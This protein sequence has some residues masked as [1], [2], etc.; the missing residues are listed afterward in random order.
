[1]QR[2]SLSPLS[3]RSGNGFVSSAPSCAAVAVF[4]AAAAVVMPVF[5]ASAGEDASSGRAR[6]APSV[7]HLAPGAEQRFKAVMLQTRL[8]GATAAQNVAWSVNG[9]PGGDDTAG[10]ITADGLYTAPAQTPKPREVHICA[11]MADAANPH[12]FATVLFEGEGTHYESVAQWSESIAQPVHLKDPHCLALDHA[13]NLLIADFEGSRVHRFTPDGMYLGDLGL[14]TG[15]APGYVI[16]PRVVQVDHEGNI[17]VSDQKKDQ[18]RIQVFSHDGQFLRTFGDK[19]I[20]PGQILRAH[21]LAFDSKHRLYV[22]DVDAMRINVYDSSGKFLQSWGQDGSGLGE[23]NAPHGIAIDANDDVFVVGYYGPCQKFTSGGKLLR[24]FAEPDPPD[25]AVYFHSICLDRWGNVY[26]TVR[27]A[28][29]YGGAIEDTQGNHVSIMKYNNNGDYV[30]SLTLN[31]SAH[32][33]NWATVAKDGTV[34]TI[35]VGN[36][37][38]GVETSAPR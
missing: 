29:G 36:E 33:E 10:R 31:V 28:G 7:V 30:A 9:I 4:I 15:E 8:K 37:R 1:M 19:G 3:N 25:S 17:F 26:L 2:A 5:A 13:G 23:F 11:E 24:V 14:G 12:L 20:N 27:G 34:Y 22:V 18:P 16:K 38:M 32:A 21:G 35:F 6:I